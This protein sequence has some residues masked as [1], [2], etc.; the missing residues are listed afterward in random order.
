MVEVGR[1]ED[2][3]V[4]LRRLDGG[5]EHRPPFVALVASG[6]HRLTDFGVG[7]PAQ[8]ADPV[9]A[10]CMGN[11]FPVEREHAREVSQLRDKILAVLVRGVRTSGLAIDF[12]QGR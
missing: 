5:R 6:Q 11:R 2:D 12:L 9:P 3:R 10:S 8:D 1:D 4:A 7:Q